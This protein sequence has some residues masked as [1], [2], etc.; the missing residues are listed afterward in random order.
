MSENS[1]TLNYW[2]V[3]GRGESIRIL[4]AL[5]GKEFKN[6]YIPLPFPLENPDDQNPPPFDDGTWGNLKPNTPW[7]TLPTLSLPSGEIIGQQRSIL[8]YL[9]KNIQYEGASLY[10]EDSKSAA[11]VDGFMDM[12]E[13]I[14][15]IL[16]GLNGTDSMET[17]PLYS[18]MLGQG[19]LDDFLNPRMIAGLGDLASQFDFLENAMSDSGPFLLGEKIS[20]ADIL[21]FAALSWW[22][23]AVFP[24]MDKMLDNRPKLSISIHAI[25][26][27]EAISNYYREM[28]N[29]RNDMPTVG[30]TNYSD[31]YK[32]FHFLCNLK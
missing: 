29:S 24:S 21:L 10:P 14:W 22:G 20:C 5:G 25:G 8:R 17:A 19:T 26:K 31:Y 15:P 13:D 32:N 16:I 27:I 18:T 2:N 1:Y 11:L 30:L 6:N 23:A 4:L 3:P 7:G 9:G 28:Q 12:L